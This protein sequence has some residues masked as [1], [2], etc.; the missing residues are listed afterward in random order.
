MLGAESNRSDERFKTRAKDEKSHCGYQ[1][2]HRDVDKEVV[3]WLKRE[4]KATPAQFMK[5][6]RQI[7]NRPK[8][9]E[10]FPNGF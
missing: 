5:F 2:W 6:L 1:E 10:R 9:R 3:E 8:M 7:Y 4:V